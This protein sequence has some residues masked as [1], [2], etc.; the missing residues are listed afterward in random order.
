MDVWYGLRTNQ[1][2]GVPGRYC[3]RAISFLFLVALQ[4]S[5]FNSR[6][7][8][9]KTSLLTFTQQ[10][11][12]FAAPVSHNAGTTVAAYSRHV[13]PFIS[14]EEGPAARASPVLSTNSCAHVLSKSDALTRFM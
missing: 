13:E 2:P 11:F 3:I 5:R 7:K 10:R 8:G 9:G 14:T 6:R 4:T 12:S 1:Q